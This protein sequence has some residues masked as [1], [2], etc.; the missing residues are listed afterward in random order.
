[1][2]ACKTGH[3]KTERILIGIFVLALL[4]KL[5]HIPGSNIMLILSSGCM[6]LL[7]LTG[8]FYLFRDRPGKEQNRLVSNIAGLCFPIMTIGI[9]FRLMHWPGG[10][11][12]LLLG[13]ISGLI[14]LLLIYQLKS[15]STENLVNYYK[16]MMFRTVIL[17]VL[18]IIF[19]VIP[20]RMSK[21]EYDRQRREYFR[22]KGQVPP[23]DSIQAGEDKIQI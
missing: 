11:F 1:M 2:F 9:L 5:L 22:E 18:A 20:F 19:F 15:K 8:P 10:K 6:A 21:Q 12:Y 7:Y 16:H 14:L 4:L 17:T 13:M 23:E 3:M